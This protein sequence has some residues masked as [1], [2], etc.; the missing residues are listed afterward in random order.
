MPAK[1]VA[2][3]ASLVK[4][5]VELLRLQHEVHKADKPNGSADFT[6]VLEAA[7]HELGIRGYD[8]VPKAKT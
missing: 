5:L 7:K 8:I 6:S 3:T 1:S 2:R 4:P